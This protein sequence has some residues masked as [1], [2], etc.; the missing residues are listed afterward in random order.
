MDILCTLRNLHHCLA[1]VECKTVKQRIDNYM[2]N[3]HNQ[4]KF[5]VFL[6]WGCFFFAS[7]HIRRTTYLSL[8]LVLWLNSGL[9]LENVFSFIYQYCQFQ[10]IILEFSFMYFSIKTY[11]D[12]YNHDCLKVKVNIPRLATVKTNITTCY[13]GQ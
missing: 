7:S 4:T 12:W 10:D 6:F 3:I 8:M 11:I 5:R 13:E 9:H 1:L 2:Y